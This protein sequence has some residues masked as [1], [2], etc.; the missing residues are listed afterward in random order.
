L[1]SKASALDKWQATYEM[2]P[3]NWA[4]LANVMIH[5]QAE[6]LL[7]KPHFE[8]KLPTGVAERLLQTF[9]ASEEEIIA[10]SAYLVM[11]DELLN[12]MQIATNNSVKVSFLTNSLAS[13]NHVAAHSAYRHHRKAILKTGANLFTVRPDAASRTQYEV[14]GFTAETFGLHGKVTI[15]DDDQ[16]FVGTLNLDPRSML[17]NT[18]MGLLIDS[19]ELNTAIRKAFLIDFSPKSSWK[20]QLSDDGDISWSSVDE[21]LTQQPA[22]NIGQR[23]M[24]FL[25]GLFPIDSEM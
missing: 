21:T 5:G 22:G 8:S 3:D 25:F 12:S 6:L 18:E 16:V 13:T 20:L 7:D 23:I 24:D 4:G 2:Q 9:R 10:I 14:P 15:I 19:P 17:L 11:T 1:R